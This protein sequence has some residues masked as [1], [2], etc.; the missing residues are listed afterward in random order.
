LDDVKAETFVG[1]VQAPLG[2]GERAVLTSLFEMLWGAPLPDVS[3]EDWK[4]FR[5]LSDPESENF[6]LGLHDYY[7]FFTYSMFRGKV[8]LAANQ[9]NL[10]LS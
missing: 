10:N 3:P 7:A 6:I 2:M 8:P 1:N 5:R 4:E 9:T